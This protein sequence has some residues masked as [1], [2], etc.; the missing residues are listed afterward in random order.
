MNFHHFHRFSRK[1]TF[2][3]ALKAA[4]FCFFSLSIFMFAQKNF[5][6]FVTG[7]FL[8]V[9][10]GSDITKKKIGYILHLSTS[11]SL[12]FSRASSPSLSQTGIWAQGCIILL[13]YA[14]VLPKSAAESDGVR[15]AFV[16]QNHQTSCSIW[17][18][19]Y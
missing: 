7:L 11:S 16:K 18:A 5:M 1:I 2:K 13:L 8:G 15:L 12:S 10:L 14:A 6:I 9:I 4:F 3:I 17:C 19:M